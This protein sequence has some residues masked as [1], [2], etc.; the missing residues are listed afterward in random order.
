[1]TIKSAE[2]VLIILKAMRGHTLTGIS[3]SQ[4]VEKLGE[5]PSQVYRGLQTL[6]KQGFVQQDQ[7]DLYYL[8]TAFVAIA[9]AHDKELEIVQARIDEVKR[10]TM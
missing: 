7:H 9:K 5:K 1:M 10:M 3:L 8:S 2:K 4:L 6:M